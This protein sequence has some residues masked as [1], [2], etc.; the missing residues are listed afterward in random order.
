[1]DIWQISSSSRAGSSRSVSSD[2]VGFS[3]RT[4]SWKT[5]KKNTISHSLTHS[6]TKNHNYFTHLGSGGIGGEESPVYVPSVSQVRVVTLLGGQTEHTLYQLLRVPGSL[7]EQLH[8]GRQQLQLDLYIERYT[9]LETCIHT[10][11]S[12]IDRYMQGLRCH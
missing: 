4:T 12:V 10:C 11:S 2:I 8:N 1:M 6:T 5:M 9:P 7:Q 3:A